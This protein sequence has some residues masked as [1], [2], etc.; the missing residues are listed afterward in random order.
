MTKFHDFDKISQF[1]AHNEDNTVNEENVNI[2]DN[3]DNADH[4][5]HADNVDNAANADNADNAHSAHN[6]DNLYNY[7]LTVKTDFKS[8]PPLPV[9][10]FRNPCDVLSF[11]SSLSFLCLMVLFRANWFCSSLFWFLLFVGP[12]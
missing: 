1:P 12:F 2:T 11:Y 3:S 9:G 4:A 10:Q 5:D 8:S 6:A 7:R